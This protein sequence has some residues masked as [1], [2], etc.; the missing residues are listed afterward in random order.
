MKIL[1]RLLLVGLAAAFLV[2]ASAA[3]FTSQSVSQGNTISSG[4]V[5]ITA[6][7]N[8]NLPFAVDNL[9]PGQSREGVLTVANTG[10]INALYSLG[11]N[12]IESE[13]SFC[14]QIKLVI[15]DENNVELYNGSLSG[16]TFGDPAFGYQSGDRVLTVG[17]SEDLR[18]V[19]SLA[20]ETDSQYQDKTCNL[21][22]VFNAE[23]N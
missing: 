2:K 5:S 15:F 21:D 14:E 8:N 19:A 22:F 13:G 23:Q 1:G 20:L 12:L 6:G 10:T 9:V 17:Q 4:K 11:V 18:L 7:G 16:A 3:I